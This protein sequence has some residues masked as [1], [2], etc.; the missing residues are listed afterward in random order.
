MREDLIAAFVEEILETGATLYAVGKGYYFFGEMDVSEDKAAEIS[1]RVNRICERYGPRD[2]LRS[3]IAEHLKS[4]GRLIE[5]DSGGK[6]SPWVG[7]STTP[8][9]STTGRDRFAS[10]AEDNGNRLG[11]PMAKH[12]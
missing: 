11:E 3:Q 1:A 9:E 6:V 2:H 5:V 4:L 8:D 7:R 12:H 10:W